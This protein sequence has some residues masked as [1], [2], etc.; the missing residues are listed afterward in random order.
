M[1]M[2]VPTVG[3]GDKNMEWVKVRKNPVI[4]DLNWMYQN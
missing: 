3:K 4:L 1:G 2:R